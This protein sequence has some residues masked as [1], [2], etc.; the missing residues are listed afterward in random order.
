MV[1]AVIAP[2]PSRR[3]VFLRGLGILLAW[4]VVVTG[5]A[6]LLLDR[7]ALDDDDCVGLECLPRDRPGWAVGLSVAAAG[8]P[9][10]VSLTVSVATLVVLVL[11]SD[12]PLPPAVAAGVGA[13]IG[14]VIACCG[15]LVV[16]GLQS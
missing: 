13:L 15:G 4:H 6:V 16:F 14:L 9:A 3:A 2:P 11:R 7:M 10:L 5:V 12:P 1:T 8:I